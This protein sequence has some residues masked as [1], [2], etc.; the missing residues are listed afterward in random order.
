MN[1]AACAYE[2]AFGGVAHRRA[3][4]AMGRELVPVGVY[5]DIFPTNTLW[6]GI[7]RNAVWIVRLISALLTLRQWWRKPATRPRT[8]PQI[9]R[10]VVL[11]AVIDVIMV[12]Y[13][14]LIVPVQFD[15]PLHTILAANPDRAILLHLMLVLAVGWGIIRTVLYLLLIA[16][17]PARVDQTK[18]LAFR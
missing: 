6:I 3:L 10:A 15:A 14:V 17:R 8:L 11:P 2:S 5:E 12:V 13:I 18:Q 16:R 9:A 4:L 1:T 7:V